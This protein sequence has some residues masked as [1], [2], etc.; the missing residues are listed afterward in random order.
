MTE[1]STDYSASASPSPQLIKR[2]LWQ[3]ILFLAGV[4]L[5]IAGVLKGYDLLRGAVTKNYF[6]HTTEVLM[7]LAAGV[8]FMSSVAGYYA[9]RAGV[10]LFTV[11]LAVS[12]HR[13]WQG[14]VN[15]GCFGPVPMNPWITATLDAAILLLLLAAMPKVPKKS[16]AVAWRKIFSGIVA[17]GIAAGM[18][19]GKVYLQPGMLHA[20]GTIT[21]GHGVIFMRPPAWDVKRF[22]AADY[23]PD[24][25]AI[26]HGKWLA[27][28]YF[29]TCPV[30][31]H[32]IAGISRRLKKSP[33]H[34]VALIQ[35]PPYGPLP[36]GLANAKMLRLAFEDTHI[37]R[38][39]FLPVLV[40]LDNGVVTRVQSYI[41]GN[42]FG[43]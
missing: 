37:W 15:C 38:P 26:M 43:F 18:I 23:I 42:W 25:R 6:F 1:N 13:A 31:Q 19:G 36:K 22:P 8:W 7:E 28:I 17:L 30:C 39:P 10:L 20:N 41:P 21:G 4:V 5:I 2:P 9:L 14:Q 35:L 27:V 16:P 11:F 40:D 3:W 24:S 12:L 34:H 29:H 32:A 33:D